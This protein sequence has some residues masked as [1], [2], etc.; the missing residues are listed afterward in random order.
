M[1]IS[2]R[3][4]QVLDWL[5]MWFTWLGDQGVDLARQG[6]DWLNDLGP[7]SLAVMTWGHIAWRWVR[8]A[9]CW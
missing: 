4:A 3:G 1:M 6:L 2:D 5:A 7:Y 9:C 8:G